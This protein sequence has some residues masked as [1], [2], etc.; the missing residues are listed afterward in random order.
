MEARKNLLVMRLSAMGD[1][2][3][4]V[5]V[6]ASFLK[7]YP[8]MGVI[9]LSSPRL[10]SLFEGMERVTFLPVDTKGTYK[11]L[12]GMVKLFKKIKKSYSFEKMIDLH[13]V[14]R[15]KEVRTM[16]GMSG[17]KSYVINKGRK[18]KKRLVSSQDKDRR[19]LKTSVQRYVE[20]F[21]E[22]GYPFALDFD[23]LMPKGGALPE[24]IAEMIRTDKPHRIA[25]A[26]FAQHAGKILPLEKTEQIVAHYAERDD[27]Q[28]L[29]FGGGKAETETFN[30]WTAKYRNTL[31]MAGKFS[32]IEEIQVL[33]H[34]DVLLSMDSSNMHLASLVGT[35]VVSVWGATHPCAGFYGYGQDPSDAVQLDL[36]CRPCSIYGKKPCARNDYA[37]LN[38]ISNDMIISRLDKHIEKNR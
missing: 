18:E 3:M 20:A 13:D 21:E 30:A 33:N 22:A 23:G 35:P 29:L 27:T 28:I 5:P 8:K 12:F 6:I 1:V 11:G 34:C 19:Q 14:I 2:A 4:T 16:V 10:S 37:C 26:P 7:A 36:P 9:M 31:S 17:K 24:R 15:S 32:L 25:I 38:G